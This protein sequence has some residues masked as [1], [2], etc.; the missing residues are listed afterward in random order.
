MLKRHC[1]YPVSLTKVELSPV[2]CKLDLA[3]EC[4]KSCLFY[5]DNFQCIYLP[6]KVCVDCILLRDI[7]AHGRDSELLDNTG[8]SAGARE[9]LVVHH[10]FR[11]CSYQLD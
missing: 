1:Q 2:L 3:S 10:E 8:F 9:A 11:P 4:V 5:I 6:S 7:S